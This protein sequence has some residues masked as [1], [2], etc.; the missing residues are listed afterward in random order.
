MSFQDYL[1]FPHLTAVANVAFGLR[2]RGASKAHAHRLRRVARAHG[3]GGQGAVK[4][5]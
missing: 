1:L 3:P 4:T 5:G 2:S